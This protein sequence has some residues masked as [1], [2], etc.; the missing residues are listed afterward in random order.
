VGAEREGSEVARSVPEAAPSP[1]TTSS[2]RA[3]RIFGMQRAAGNRV[4]RELLELG[5]PKL[6]V[7]AAD[8][9]LEEEADAIARRVVDG[10]GGADGDGDD[11]PK[12]GNNDHPGVQRR[13]GIGAEGGAVDAHTE[14]AIEAARRGGGRPL[15]PA[16]RRTMEDGFGGADFSAVRVHSGSG[17]AELNDRIQAKAFTIGSDIFFRGAPPDAGRRDGMEVVAHELAHTLQQGATAAPDTTRR[18]HEPPRIRRILQTRNQVI[19]AVGAPKEDITIGKRVLKAMS[20]KY[21]AVLTALDAYH[22]YIAETKV[23]QSIIANQVR[24]IHWLLDDVVTACQEYLGGEHE[25]GEERFQWIQDLLNKA[26]IE[27]RLIKDLSKQAAVLDGRYWRD[28]IPGLGGASGGLT[29]PPTQT[30]EEHPDPGLEGKA[31]KAGKLFA[32]LDATRGTSSLA[33]EAG[34]YA[35]NDKLIIHQ[36]KDKAVVFVEKYTTEKKDGEDKLGTFEVT[37]SGY[38]LAANTKLGDA[39]HVAAGNDVP[40]FTREPCPDDVNQGAIGD[41]YLMAALAAIA[42]NNP[43]AIYNM[44]KDN[45]DGTVTVKMYKPTDQA[46]EE[47][48]FTIKKTIVSDGRHS[49]GALW[50][51]LLEKAYATMGLAVP[52]GKSLI[53]ST[54]KSYAKIGDGGHSDTAFF[55]LTGHPPA[56]ATEVRSTKLAANP[57]WGANEQNNYKKQA[58]DKMR[59]YALFN[60]SEPLLK[61]WMDFSKLHSAK[62]D[63]FRTLEEF[64]QFFA[65][66]NLHEEVRAALLPALRKEV[67]AKRGSGSYSDG[68][69]ELYLKIAQALARGEFV[70]AGTKEEIATEKGGPKSKGHSGGEDVAEGLVGSHAYSILAVHE[71]T[72]TNGKVRKFIRLRNPWGKSD[73]LNV[74]RVYRGGLEGDLEIETD[75]KEL[76]KKVKPEFDLELTDF[77]KHFSK[78]YWS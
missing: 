5:Q 55:I 27:K 70:A 44:M 16:L 10:I 61:K 1:V 26:T 13:A 56:T 39:Q 68:Q 24:E 51:P 23:D 29:V 72:G 31:T 46:V 45:G 67:P 8:D 62:L 12:R 25:H 22:A 21:K 28:A 38:T 40:I 19:A 76:K 14:H 20:T 42:R 69:E 17:A 7:G 73:D 35:K 43:A 54:S 63:K 74:G 58:Y 47:K 15:D 57:L 11:A 30:V 49:E 75:P 32:S 59:S 78:V 41:C 48:Y 3:N 53:S 52:K 2:P 6:E 34:S 37:G 50:V 60:G 9:K 18:K 66:N 36:T 65:A 4:T 71:V 77:T 33:K 64:E